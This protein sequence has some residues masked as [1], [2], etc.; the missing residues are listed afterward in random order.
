MRPL[1]SIRFQ[2]ARGA[3]SDTALRCR[4]AI[5]FFAG[6]LLQ[7]PLDELVNL[8]NKLGA[9]IFCVQMIA[10]WQD[11]NH[12]K[13]DQKIVSI[14]FRLPIACFSRLGISAPSGTKYALGLY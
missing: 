1:H 12:G 6:H 11:F 9:E 13:T 7:F 3:P 4:N 5:Q 10:F 8:L 2:N 14:C